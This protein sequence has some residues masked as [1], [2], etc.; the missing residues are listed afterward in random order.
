MIEVL[1]LKGLYIIYM[2]PDIT[3]PGVNI[4]AAY[5]P[6]SPTAVPGQSLD[7]YFM[8]GTSMACP[9]VGGV[10]AYIKTF[11]P[12]WSPSAVKSAIMTTGNYQIS[13]QY[14]YFPQERK[15]V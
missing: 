12:D 2:Q 4:L 5:S 9:H 13:N 8:S 10:A 14:I 1:T 7:Y 15:N 11:H 6:M 3:A